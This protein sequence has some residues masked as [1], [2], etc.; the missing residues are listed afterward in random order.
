MMYHNDPELDGRFMGRIS[1]DFIRVADQLREA[2]YQIRSRGFSP[3]PIFPVSLQ[4]I[5]LGKL[6]VA[7]GELYGNSWYY[8]ATYVDEFVQRKLIDENRLEAFREAY[9]DP[10][11]YCCLFV[12]DRD[13]TGFVF[14]PYPED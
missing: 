9:K 7:A 13:V 5:P 8:Y 11:E 3:Y 12:V 2:S 10:D 14:I 6:L 4:E 1:S